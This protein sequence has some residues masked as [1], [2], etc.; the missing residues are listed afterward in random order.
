MEIAT[1]RLSRS[2][3][4]RLRPY[5]RDLRGG[6][7]QKLRVRAHLLQQSVCVKVHRAFDRGGGGNE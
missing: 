1:L 3:E 2:K 5:P 6:A 4:E 7:G